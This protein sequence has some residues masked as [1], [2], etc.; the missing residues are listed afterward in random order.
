[1][2][3]KVIQCGFFNTIKGYT[4]TCNVV[5]SFTR[6]YEWFSTTWCFDIL[7]LGCLWNLTIHH[8]KVILITNINGC[9]KASKTL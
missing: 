7:P 5:F 9:L 8:S 6:F 1:M 2:N 4:Y 3:Y